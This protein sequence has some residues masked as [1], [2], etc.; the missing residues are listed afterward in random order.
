[1]G[2]AIAFLGGAVG[3]RSPKAPTTFIPMLFQTLNRLAARVAGKLPL[4]TVLVVPFVL[5]IVGTVG[6]VGY[7]SFKSGQN[8]VENLAHQLMAQVG[9][10]ISDRLT[11][12][13]NA[14][15]DI[16]A[17]NRLAVEQGTL[18]INDFEQLRQQFWQETTLH[19][20]I[21]GI[22]FG[23]EPGELIWYGRFHSEEIVKQAEKLTGEDLSIGI[24]FLMSV[25]SSDPGK[26]H[27]Y[28]VD[29]K[30][31]PRQL[32]YTIHIDNRTTPWYRYAKA[33]SPQTWS[34]I[35]VYK[36]LP[37]LGIFALA[38]IYD[39]AGKWRGVFGS[40][41]TLSGISTFLE[42]LKFSPSGQTFILERSGNLV[43]TS[44]LEIPFVQPA[45]G[46]PT[47]LLAVNSKDA[48]TRDITRQLIKKFGNFHTLQTTQQLNLVSNHERQFVRVAP[49]RDNYGLDWLV[50]VVVPESDFMEQIHNNNC[51]TI[52]L[53]IGALICSVSVGIL[54]TRWIS[55]PIVRLNSAAKHITNGKWDQPVEIER[56][57]EVGELANS[58]NT[59]AAQL[60]QSFGELHSLN[61]ALAQSESQLHQSLEA[62]PL[63][64]A[65]HD[66]TGKVTYF[67][68]T[69]KRLLGIDT[70]PDAASEELAAAY[71]LYRQN[72]LYPIEELPALRAI[73]GETVFLDDIEL[74]RDGKIIPFEVHAAPIT[75]QQGNIIYAI[76]A[77]F[78]ITERKQSQKILADYH[79]ILKTEVA[80]KTEALQ[81]SQ[82][83]FAG[84]LEIANDAIITVDAEQRITLFNQ[85]AEHIFGYQADE[86]LGQPLDFLLPAGVRAIH[87]QHITAFAKSVGR[88]RRM[89]ERREIFGRR[90]DGT[91]FPAEASISKLEI[92]GEKIFTTILRDISDRKQFEQAIIESEERFQEIAR[93]VD[94]FFFVRSASSGQSLYVSP[95]Y[96]KIWG[97]SCASLYENPDSWIEAVHPQDRELVLNSIREQFQGNAVHR[98][99]RIIRPDGSIRWVVA[100]ISVVRD[101]A[102]QPLRFIGLAEDITHLKQT[103]KEIRELST[104]LENAVE[105]ISQLDTQGRYVTVNKAYANMTGYQPEEMIGMEW[106]RTVHP[107]DCENM[108][109]AYQQMLEVGKVEAEARGRRKDGS[110]FYKQLVMIAAYDEQ[111]N[112]TGHYC[113]MKDITERKRTEEALREREEQLQL[114]LEGSGDGFWDWHIPTGEVYFSSWYLEMLGYDAHELPQEFNTWD[115]LIHP[116]DKPWVMEILNAHLS[117]SSVPYKFDY[118]VLTK[119]GEWKWIANYGKVVA[120][121]RNGTPLRMTGTHR[122]VSDKKLAEQQLQWKEALLRSMTE[123]SPLAFYVVD[124]RTDAILYFNHRFCEIWGIEHLEERMQQGVLT[125]NDIIPDCI[126]LLQDVVA[127]AESC[128][129]LQSEENRIVIED[130]IPFADGRTIR[131]FS[132]QIRDA[133]DHYFGRLYIFEDITERKLSQAALQQAKE[134]AET[135]NLAKSTFLAS[136]SHEL[137]TPLNGILGYAQILQRDKNCTPKQKEGVDIIYQC[138][139]HLL[140]LINDILDLSKIEAGKL[141]LYPENFN[142]PSFLTGLTEIFRLKAIQKSLTFTYLPSSELPTIVHADQKRLRQVLM[143]LLSNAVKF[144]DTGGVTFKVEVLRK[145][146]SQISNKIQTTKNQPPTT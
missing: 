90:K 34:P 92:N 49:Y 74:H 12:Y 37:T 119:S 19:P 94:Q 83:R 127:F 117:D 72:Q 10:R 28:L 138:G 105:G 68:P 70:I 4:Q 131:R 143:N 142:F 91:E 17:A 46:E 44:T 8:A 30:G 104:A 101:D 60:Q 111:N 114:A 103:E 78:D 14:P 129:P 125:N 126:P 100:D 59:M 62:L 95:A 38:P 58:F 5:Q 1:M 139:T 106:P 24:P 85:G 41:F 13:L 145:G 71:Q 23:N 76:T 137:R 116:D 11:T 98:E 144:T 122:D 84:I 2:A 48:R 63:G 36:I 35:S 64:V 18:D 87:R 115:R 88:A 80:Q 130:E 33:T 32:I 39:A 133:S 45:T 7:L 6:L 53:C 89:G 81:A 52:L 107:E 121:D 69:A 43:A 42:Q 146:Q 77:F 65:I 141:E 93:N 40:D 134:T 20:L 66:T 9:E 82:T 120:R 102:G 16:V 22:F 61:T 118:R 47:R 109:A 54:A 79:R 110:I 73:K 128:K 86:V 75:D 29:K 55:K 124:N 97:R 96:E 108:I 56:A 132:A 27:Y 26:R 21:Q 123:A 15:Q 99:Y 31:N 57:D 51:T 50:V 140:T 113:F 67:N 135:A 112:F 3:D 25:K 136:M